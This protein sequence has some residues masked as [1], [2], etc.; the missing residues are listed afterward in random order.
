MTR[1]QFIDQVSRAAIEL[2]DTTLARLDATVELLL[3]W[4]RTINLVAKATLEEVWTRHVLDSAQL[5]RL[6]P[7]EA[8][9]L[10]DLGS[11]A[12]F[13][14]LVLAA[15][16]PDLN[17]ILVE[18]DSR[19]AAFLAEAA[20]H[21]KLALP[22]RIV[23]GRIEA[24]PALEAD[25]LTARALAPLP[26][27][28]EWADRHRSDTAICLFHKGKGWQAELTDAM[29]DW[30]IQSQPFASVTDR[31]SVVLRIG[32]YRRHATGR[33]DSGRPHSRRPDAGHPARGSSAPQRPATAPVRDRQ[34]KGRRGKDND[35]DQPRHRPGG[36][37]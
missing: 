17:V 8:R 7:P 28:L 6:I 10:A 34:S 26:K 30:D 12:G 15:M 19:K 24:I 27:L 25:I 13:P 23:I 2:P 5:H 36:S 22:P 33:P 37:R 18:S 11:G 16:R 14:G 20:R 4:N 21:M 1:D 29:Q 31:D 32:H 3:R 35:G 9:N